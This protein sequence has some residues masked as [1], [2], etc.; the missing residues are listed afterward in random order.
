MI[1]VLAVGL[2]FLVGLG[3]YSYGMFHTLLPTWSNI[4]DVMNCG[5]SH[6]APYQAYDARTL[7]QSDLPLC[8]VAPGRWTRTPY[9]NG[10]FFLALAVVFGSAMV[11]LHRSSLLRLATSSAPGTVTLFLLIF[12]I[13]MMLF[14]LHFNFVEGTLTVDWA[15]HVVV[16]ALLGGAATGLLMWYILVRRLRA[17]AT[18]NNRS[19]GP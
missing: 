19:R 4:A 5:I 15:F 1:R 10:P 8:E 16:Y 13:P 6:G 18:S 11:A 14:G 2:G 7:G 12:G 3:I 9:G 17:R